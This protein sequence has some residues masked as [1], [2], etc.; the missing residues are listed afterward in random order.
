MICTMRH[1]QRTWPGLK[2]QRGQGFLSGLFADLS[3]M[4]RTVPG[5]WQ[6]LDKWRRRIWNVQVCISS[7]PVL[8][9]KCSTY[10]CNQQSRVFVRVSSSSQTQHAQDRVMVFGLLSGSVLMFP[11]QRMAPS[12]IQGDEPE[13]RNHPWD[14]LT[15]ALADCASHIAFRFTASHRKSLPWLLTVSGTGGRSSWQV[16]EDATWSVAH[17]LFYAHFTPIYPGLSAFWSHWTRVSLSLECSPLPP[18]T[19]PWHLLL[20]IPHNSAQVIL[21]PPTSQPPSG[22]GSYFNPSL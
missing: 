4:P 14:S 8:T 21:L 15:H 18:S 16:S 22:S 12:S 5:T 19:P 7:Q 2:N 9:P 11:V 3:H 1:I 10:T 17:L 13:T 20:F 6:A